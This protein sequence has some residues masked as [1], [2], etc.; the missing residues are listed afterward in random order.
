MSFFRI[1]VTFLVIGLLAGIL[2]F[3]GVG[4]TAIFLAKVAIMAL[5]LKLFFFL[6]L[7]LAA[8]FFVKHIFAGRHP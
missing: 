2:G 5:F 4:G 7:I 8:Y 6:F 1:A 3:G